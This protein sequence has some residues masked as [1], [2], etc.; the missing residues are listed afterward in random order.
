MSETRRARDPIARDF[1]AHRSLLWAIAFRMTGVAADADDVV[2]DTFARLLAHPPNRDRPLRPWLVKVA[3]N[4]ARDQLRRR[5]RVEYVGPW[6]PSPVEDEHA[7]VVDVS[8]KNTVSPEQRYTIH[9]SATIAFLLAVEK[10]TPMRRAVLILRDVFDYSGE[11]TAEALGISVDA[12]KQNL[13][14]AHKSLADYDAAR[15]SFDAKQKRNEVALGRLFAA[16]AAGDTASVEKLLAK[17]VEAHSDGGGVYAASRIVLRGPAKVALVYTRLTQLLARATSSVKL[18]HINGTLAARIDIDNAEAL[19]KN[20][21]PR[22]FI[23]VDTNDAGDI[24][25]VYSMMAPA[26]LTAFVDDG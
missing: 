22:T 25:R 11:E 8:D 21:A 23:T 14:R 2:Q 15:G 3:M 12:V 18:V 10:L 16:L 9:E 13:S 5:R 26:K 6:L 7:G 1:D 4:V 20:A 19:L 24:V 17:E